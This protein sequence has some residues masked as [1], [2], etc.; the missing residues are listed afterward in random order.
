MDCHFRLQPIFVASV[1]NTK[2]L[3]APFI[4]YK[5]DTCSLASVF[6]VSTLAVMPTSP[7]NNFRGFHSKPS[8]LPLRDPPQI[9]TVEIDKSLRQIVL[10]PTLRDRIRR[11]FLHQDH[12]SGCYSKASSTRSGP[13]LIVASWIKVKTEAPKRF[14][15]NMF[16]VFF[17]GLFASFGILPAIFVSI[18]NSYAFDSVER[19]TKAV[20]KAAQDAPWSRV[21]G[22]GSICV[23][24]ALSWLRWG[25]GFKCF[26]LTDYAFM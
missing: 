5:G 11:L 4:R 8:H 10:S 24:V 14:H 17:I 25:I 2:P 1:F 21:I 6:R 15:A 19:T 20:I 18:R 22:T 12:S 7:T 13:W 3:F 23:V 16:V 26:W 9:E